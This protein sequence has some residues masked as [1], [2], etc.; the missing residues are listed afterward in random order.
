MLQSVFNKEK[1]NLLQQIEEYKIRITEFQQRMKQVFLDLEKIQNELN[2]KIN[3]AQEYKIKYESLQKTQEMQTFQYQREIEQIQ[4]QIPS[5]S[6]EYEIKELREKLQKKKEKIK[7]CKQKVIVNT[8]TVIVEKP[9]EVERIVEVIKYVPVEKIV[10]QIIPP[11]QPIVIQECGVQKEVE[12]HNEEILIVKDQKIQDLTV[13]IDRITKQYNELIESYSELESEYNFVISDRQNILNQIN[14]YNVYIKQ[15]ELQYSHKNQ[16]LMDRIALIQA[17][18]SKKK[19]D[20]SKII[21]K[22]GEKGVP[23]VERI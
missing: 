8:E 20:P 15:L 19:S 6:Y 7:Q 3:L 1:N 2:S 10:K 17:F 14:N 13:Q 16:E 12:N 4:S 22:V 11:K 9:V 5:V 23:I 21:I 18:L